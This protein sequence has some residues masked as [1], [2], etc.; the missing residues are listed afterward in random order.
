MQVAWSLNRSP[1]TSER[2]GVR[3]PVCAVCSSGYGGGVGNSCHQCS[4]DF[5]AGMYVVFVIVFLLV[6]ALAAL[7]AVYLVSGLIQGYLWVTNKI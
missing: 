2:V 1:D 5:K 3:M 6:V 7:L 4:P